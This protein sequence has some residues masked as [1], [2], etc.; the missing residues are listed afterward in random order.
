MLLEK[1][2]K[3]FALTKLGAENLSKRVYLAQYLI[4]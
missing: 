1:V 2:Q 3:K 4:S